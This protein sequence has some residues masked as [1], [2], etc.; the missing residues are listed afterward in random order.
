MY[1]KTFILTGTIETPNHK[2]DYRQL[3]FSSN[4]FKKLININPMWTLFKERCLFVDMSPE[5]QR[6]RTRNLKQIPAIDMTLDFIIEYMESAMKP[7]DYFA[8]QINVNPNEDTLVFRLIYEMLKCYGGKLTQMRK[9]KRYLITNIPDYNIPTGISGK[10][11]PV[12]NAITVTSANTLNEPSMDPL[13]AFGIFENLKDRARGS[14]IEA[15]CMYGRSEG[16]IQAAL[17]LN[18][19]RG[20][21]IRR[22]GNLFFC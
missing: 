11:T 20:I 3:P 1:N 10:F 4:E 8:L 21:Q 22:G 13:F 16:M 7:Y 6:I 19:V 2:V 18:K 15:V 14:Q 9:P 5:E 12:K 17:T